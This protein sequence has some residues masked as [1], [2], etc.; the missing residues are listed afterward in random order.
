MVDSNKQWIGRWNCEVRFLYVGLY[1]WFVSN[2]NWTAQWFQFIRYFP[3]K[4]NS[5][6]RENLPMGWYFLKIVYFVNVMVQLGRKCANLLEMMHF[7]F[8]VKYLHLHS[9]AMSVSWLVKLVELVLTYVNI[10]KRNKRIHTE[11]DGLFFGRF[12]IFKV[13]NENRIKSI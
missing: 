10:R 4:P 13:L 9:I 6:H 5:L 3:S 12:W 8:K 11:M 1:L 2:P 7:E